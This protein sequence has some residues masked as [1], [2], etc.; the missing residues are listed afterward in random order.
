MEAVP[1]RGNH[2]TLCQVLDLMGTGGA[3]LGIYHDPTH[4]E[5]MDC[6][7]RS[8]TQCPTC[9]SHVGHCPCY[10]QGAKPF[11]EISK[12]VIVEFLEAIFCPLEVLPIEVVEFVF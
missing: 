4:S 11:R 10:K 12:G 2:G 1:L 7:G 3:G 6:L 9:V 8:G 5:C